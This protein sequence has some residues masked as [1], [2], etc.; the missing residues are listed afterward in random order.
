MTK[1]QERELTAKIEKLSS[2]AR[3]LYRRLQ[4]GKFYPAWR[5]D[6]PAVMTELI[7]AG[8]VGTCGRVVKIVACYVPVHNYKSFQMETFE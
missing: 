7:D 8:L 2:R 1:K 3:K 4:A 6:T 5:H